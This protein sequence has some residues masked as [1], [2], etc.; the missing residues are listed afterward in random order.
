DRSRRDGRGRACRRRAG[1]ARGDRAL[2][3]RPVACHGTWPPGA[4]PCKA[5][6]P[7]FARGRR[8]G[9][10]LRKALVTPMIETLIVAK[11]NF[12]E[13]NRPFPVRVAHLPPASRP[14]GKGDAAGTKWLADCSTG[15]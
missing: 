14:T 15:L 5:E 12:D 13:T 6:F 7:A 10:S 8:R 1:A 3:C 4:F 2:S 11:D 9:K